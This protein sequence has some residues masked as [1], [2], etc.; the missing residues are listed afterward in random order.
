M[1][2]AAKRTIKSAMWITYLVLTLSVVV[3]GTILCS[4]LKD[5]L[6]Y[7]KSEIIELSVKDAQKNEVSNDAPVNLPA[8]PT[9]ADKK[10][11]AN[12]K[13]GFEASDDKVVWGDMTEVEI[14]KVTYDE[15]G[16]VTVDGVDDKVFAPGTGN[17][18]NFSL[19]NTGNVALD[20]T[21]SA[22]VLFSHEKDT[23]PI[24]VRMNQFDGSYLVGTKDTYVP[25]ADL[26]GVTDNGTLAPGKY[27]NY[28][29][30][31]EWPFEGPKG[32]AYD[33]E[34]GN[35]AVNE[36]ITMTVILRTTAEADYV[37]DK[38]PDT[39][40]TGITVFVVIA[41]AALA[42]MLVLVVL[43]K[44]SKEEQQENE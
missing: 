7:E 32:D 2:N 25:A 21:L 33:T 29:L 6:Q 27:A 11:S 13:P 37:Y 34:L 42:A 20:Y 31:W 38:S 30:D 19:K 5:F 24:T 22:E 26:N 36:D 12:F 9:E 39:G 41:I 44:K 10:V 1:N 16:S 8:A 40:D 28:A 43:L 18:Y 3:T 4:R 17:T 35:K 15:T 23:I 14:F